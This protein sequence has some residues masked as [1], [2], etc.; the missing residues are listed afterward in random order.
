MRIFKQDNKEL[1]RIDWV[2]V[3]DIAKTKKEEDSEKI[4]TN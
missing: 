2:E 3:Q 1:K 4:I